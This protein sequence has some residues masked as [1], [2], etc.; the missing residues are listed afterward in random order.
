MTEYEKPYQNYSPYYQYCDTAY[1]YA[2]KV[3]EIECRKGKCDLC[4][5]IGYFGTWHSNGIWGDHP[6]DIITEQ[7]S[8]YK[9]YAWSEIQTMLKF[10]I[11]STKFRNRV[12]YWVCREC[13][14]KWVMIDKELTKIRKRVVFE[15][16]NKMLLQLMVFRIDYDTD[17]VYT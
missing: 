5:R 6:R 9:E 12:V 16:R 14:Y 13:R 17:S 7:R 2:N 1:L 4:L 10:P 11:D 15:E 3:C 8:Y